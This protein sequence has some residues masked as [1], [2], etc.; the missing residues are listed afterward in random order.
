MVISLT[1]LVKVYPCKDS[2]VSTWVQGVFPL[3]LDLEAKASEKVLEC[4]WDCLFG[5]LVPTKRASTTDYALP[6]LILTALVSNHMANY[7]ASAC[8]T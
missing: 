6:W 4:I 5:Y 1:E 2:L 3:I 8:N 7:L